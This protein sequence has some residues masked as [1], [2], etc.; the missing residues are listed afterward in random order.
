MSLQGY[1]ANKHD[2]DR[3]FST[4][5]MELHAGAPFLAAEQTAHSSQVYAASAVLS[6]CP[7]QLSKG[8]LG[9]QEVCLVNS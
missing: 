6:A 4:K 9:R 3:H 8:T 5:P 1:V 2:I 7:E